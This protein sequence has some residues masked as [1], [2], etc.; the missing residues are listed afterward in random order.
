MFTELSE[1]D[2][3]DIYGGIFNDGENKA[4]LGEYYL[5]FLDAKKLSSYKYK[6]DMKL[7]NIREEL[8]K[9]KCDQYSSKLRT[10]E[11]PIRL[12]LTNLAI[13]LTLLPSL[14]DGENPPEIR[15]VI[16]N[17]GQKLSKWRVL[18]IVLDEVNLDIEDN[19]IEEFMYNKLIKYAKYKFLELDIKHK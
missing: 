6:E 15:W 16:W 12:N 9:I 1:R 19:L 3:L 17:K 10:F 18:E 11:S 2:L 14:K 4:Y 5:S 8:E 7:S 13:E